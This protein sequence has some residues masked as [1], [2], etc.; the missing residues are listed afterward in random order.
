MWMDG[1]RHYG[2]SAAATQPAILARAG[3]G[4]EVLEALFDKL[5]SL[6][7]L[8]RVPELYDIYKQ[9]VTTDLTFN[10]LM[11]FLPWLHSWQERVKFRSNPSVKTGV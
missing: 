6:D 10:K 7:G 4:G 2:T 8:R 5:I 1:I 3:G 9:N 11:G